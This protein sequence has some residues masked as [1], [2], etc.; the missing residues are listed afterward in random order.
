M[1][2]FNTFMDVAGWEILTTIILGF[3]TWLG[4]QAKTVYERHVNTKEKQETVLYVVNCVEQ[5]ATANNWNSQQKKTE[6]VARAVSIL[7]SKGIVCDEL[8]ID[9]LIEA[10]VLGFKTSF[11]EETTK[12]T[13]INNYNDLVSETLKSIEKGG[14]ENED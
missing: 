6:A 13:T 5:I 3:A 14:V 2:A 4:Y 8:E 11:N 1:E 10:V 7:N 12:T 9:T